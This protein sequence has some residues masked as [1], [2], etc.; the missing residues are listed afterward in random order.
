MTKVV[1]QPG[2]RELRGKMGDWTYRR[3]YGK[4]TVM[5]TPD[6][7]RVKWSKA[8]KANRERF[9]KAIAY[10]RRA[11]ADPTVR[12]HYETAGKE[13]GRQPFRVAVSDYYAGKNLLEK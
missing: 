12:V 3:M 10:A 4:Q 11:M 8:Q 1:L 6:M 7:S 2:L 13:T 5:K 9:R